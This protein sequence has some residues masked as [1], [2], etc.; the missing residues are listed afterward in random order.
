MYFLYKAGFNFIVG[1]PKISPVFTALTK[2]HVQYCGIPGHC[3][4]RVQG[5]EENTRW[6]L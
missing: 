5:I 6:I 3:K 4:L 2:K 1:I